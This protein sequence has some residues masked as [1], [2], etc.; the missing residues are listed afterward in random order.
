MCMIVDANVCSEIFG[1]S[2]TKRG[3]AVFEW[4]FLGN[5]SLV[6]A[7]KLTKELSVVETTRLAI[8][9]LKQAGKVITCA[10]TEIDK[11]IKLLKATGELKS[12]D[13]HIIA[14]ARCSGC[15]R[16]FSDDQNAIKDFKNNNLIKKPPGKVYRDIK[17][18]RSVLNKT[19]VCVGSCGT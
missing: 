13:S 4:L 5:G 17:H 12:N 16:F 14:L 1:K 10:K 6:A 2:K 7:G 15:R 9:A 3:K 18:T 8:V 11:D 19:K